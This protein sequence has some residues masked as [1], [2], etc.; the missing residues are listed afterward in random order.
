MKEEM[1]RAVLFY[2]VAF[3]CRFVRNEKYRRRRRVVQDFRTSPPLSSIRFKIDIQ[4]LF[5]LGSN[6]QIEYL[7]SKY[8]IFGVWCCV[9]HLGNFSYT[10]LLK[11]A[12]VWNKSTNFASANRDVAQLVAHYVRDVGVGRSSRLIP[13]AER[14]TG[15]FCLSLFICY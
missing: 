7:K 2:F 10:F 5:K 12:C 9:V 8:R 14:Q 4:V 13:T 3:G 1:F 15:K 6:K 11:N